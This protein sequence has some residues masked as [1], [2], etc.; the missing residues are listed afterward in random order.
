VDL[1]RA[2]LHT[3]QTIPGVGP[4]LARRITDSRMREGPFRS[5]ADLERVPGIGPATAA[6]IW[7]FA[8]GKSNS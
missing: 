2:D 3:L 5:A 1:N 4:A 8:S 7:A 6:R